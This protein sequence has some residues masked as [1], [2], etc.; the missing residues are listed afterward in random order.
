MIIVP[1]KAEHLQALR[2][3]PAQASSA[4]LTAA[5]AERVGTA[6][7]AM[8]EGVPVACGGLFEIWPNRA[9]AWTYLGIDCG[10]EFQALH[11][12]V[13]H[14]IVTAPWRRI[15]SYVDASFVN[16]HRWMRV[17]GFEYEGLLRSFMADGTDMALYARVRC[18]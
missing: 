3:Q 18:E 5:E 12:H 7:T 2:L 6:Y 4:L 17:L 10:R 13:M 1:F 14:K 9:I 11:R 8:S 15:E 16:G